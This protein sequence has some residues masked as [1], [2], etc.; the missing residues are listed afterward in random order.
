MAESVI[1]GD[2]AT[3][4]ETAISE[5]TAPYQILNPSAATLA[6]LPETNLADAASDSAVV[7]AEDELKSV[8]D[9]FKQATALADLVD[10]G[11]PLVT[12]TASPETTAI[13]G[14]DGYYLFGAT[15]G[16]VTAIHT[17]EGSDDFQDF[18]SAQID[19]ADQ[20]ALRVPG[21]SRIRDTA[22]EALSEEF[23]ESLDTALAGVEEFPTE[24]GANG[25]TLLLILAARHEEL[26]YDVSKWGEDIELASK[27]TFSRTKTSLEEE[28]LVDTE[29]VPIDI[30]RPRLRLLVGT[31]ELA[32]VDDSDLIDYLV[33]KVGN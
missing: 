1:R 9:E 5:L 24:A 33:D 26:L 25:V 13:V 29:S 20:F 11:M 4:I 8:R 27:A 16:T 3:V 18:A 32:S 30:G 10:D 15:N 23:A 21:M 14:D 31:D 6:A 7:A 28:G 19:E 22:T 12:Q 17:K 2:R